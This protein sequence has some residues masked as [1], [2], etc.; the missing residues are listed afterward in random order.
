MS[1]I[2]RVCACCPPHQGPP[3]LTWEEDEVHDVLVTELRGLG[4]WGQQRG[5]LAAGLQQGGD[6][7]GV[8]RRLAL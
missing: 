5:T 4:S 3:T 7:G 8:G 6:A 2:S 1:S